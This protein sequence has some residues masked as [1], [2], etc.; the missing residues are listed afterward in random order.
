MVW[1]ILSLIFCVF[2]VIAIWRMIGSTT[3]I[4]LDLK[5]QLPYES[6]PDLPGERV[7]FEAQDGITLPGVLIRS[8]H[9]PDGRTVIFCPE[10]GG[11]LSNYQKYAEHVVE[12]G[13][14]LFAFEFRGHGPVHVSE[15]YIP[16]HWPT[17][18]ELLDLLG[19]LQFVRA[20]KDVN[21]DKV[22]LFGVSK[23]AC[24]A[25][26]VAGIDGKV[27]A[28]ISD[29]AF[30][31][32]KTMLN[33]IERW[34]PIFL[35]SEFFWRHVPRWYLVGLQKVSMVVS[36]MIHGCKFISV[37]DYLKKWPGIPILFIHGKRDNFIRYEQ[38]HDLES[39]VSQGEVNVWIVPKARHNESAVVAREE[40]QD[41]TIDFLNTH[42]G[43]EAREEKVIPLSA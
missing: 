24:M 29:S 26:C 6:G 5:I 7:V 14:H 42:M 23:G 17:R 32:K 16:T 31:T 3:K 18:F 20:Q 9:N 13:Y 34:G 37:S 43:S 19:A 39:L 27:A 1:W 2:L 21:P 28:V 10:F 38:A 30:S 8:P 4:F 12:A 15:G 25:L 33:Y 40:Y 41:R 36:G 11:D 22:A 35:R